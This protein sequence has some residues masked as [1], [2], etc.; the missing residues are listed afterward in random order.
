MNIE[1]HI[2][3]MKFREEEQRRLADTALTKAQTIQKERLELQ[4]FLD[5]A[6]QEKELREKEL[7]TFIGQ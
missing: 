4:N 3:A 1:F 5:K 7:R 6:D 2:E